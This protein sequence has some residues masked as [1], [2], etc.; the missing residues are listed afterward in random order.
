MLGL[1]WSPTERIRLICTV[2][3]RARGSIVYSLKTIMYTIWK[4]TFSSTTLATPTTS[5][6]STFVLSVQCFVIAW[7]RLRVDALN[8]ECWPVIRSAGHLD[9]SHAQTT[10]SHRQWSETTYE[11]DK[12][13]L[14]QLLSSFCWLKNI[15]VTDRNRHK[16]RPR[17]VPVYLVF[18]YQLPELNFGTPQAYQTSFCSKLRTGWDINFVS[19]EFIKYA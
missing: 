14:Q 10:R 1:L 5:M 9:I 6:N 15:S 3:G 12:I 2:A 17:T 19:T 18:S 16:D 11:R 13:N 7:W 8:I 4:S